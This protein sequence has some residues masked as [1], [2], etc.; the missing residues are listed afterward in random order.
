MKWK[1]LVVKKQSDSDFKSDKVSD[2]SEEDDT[3]LT[4]TENIFK[5]AENLGKN[6]ISTIDNLS[7]PF[8][9]QEA[10]KSKSKSTKRIF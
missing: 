7:G 9:F 4:V 6:R 8:Y 5:A 10:S 1:N 3:S 2:S